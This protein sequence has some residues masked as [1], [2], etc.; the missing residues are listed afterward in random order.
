MYIVCVFYYFIFFEDYQVLCQFLLDLCFVNEIMGM[1]FLVYEGINGMIVGLCKGI[2]VVIVYIQLLSGCVNFEWKESI[3]SEKFFLCMK[4]KL[5]KEIVILGQFNV[6]LMVYV[7]NYV[8]FQDWN[9]LIQ[10]F[11]V[12]IIDMCN[13]YEVLIGIFQGVVDLEIVSFCDFFVWW[14]ENK[15]CFYNKC[16]VMFCIGGIWCEKLMNYLLG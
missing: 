9:E 5:K 12:V 1:L 8:D 7:G 10:L 4:V 11:D 2:D 16:I 15:D 6:D 14:E 13:D 3:V